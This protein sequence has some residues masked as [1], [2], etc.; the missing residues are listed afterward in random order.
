MGTFF[1]SVDLIGAKSTVLLLNGMQVIKTT[2]AILLLAF[3]GSAF[4]EIV[5]LKCGTPPA[6]GF[7]LL[8]DASRTSARLVFDVYP[9]VISG[10][11]ELTDH[12]YQMNFPSSATRHEIY[13]LV[14]R[15][16]GKFF[17]EIGMPPFGSFTADNIS[18]VGQCAG[19]E[20]EAKP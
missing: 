2:I 3:S 13:V 17:Y 4:A 7:Y 11:L 5:T 20:N 19:I 6:Q 18:Q 15:I 10:K 1:G 16:S 9:K 14:D 8:I 12:H